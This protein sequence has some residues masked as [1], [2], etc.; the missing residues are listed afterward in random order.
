MIVLLLKEEEGG[1]VRSLVLPKDALA[2]MDHRRLRRWLLWSVEARS[3][4]EKTKDG[5]L[6]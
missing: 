1:R 6:S 4:P 3:K 2:A 5:A